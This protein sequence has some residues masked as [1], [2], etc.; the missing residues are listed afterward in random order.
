MLRAR[1][2]D[3]GFDLSKFNK[4]EIRLLSRDEPTVLSGGFIK[5]VLP[6]VLQGHIKFRVEPLTTI[7]FNNWR[8]MEEPQLLERLITL[9]LHKYPSSNQLVQ[10]YKGEAARLFSSAADEFLAR[11]AL[12]Q[13]E[14]MAAVLGRR[15]ISVT[16]KLGIAANAAAIREWL[17]DFKATHIEAHALSSLEMLTDKLL[18]SDSLDLSSLHYSVG[19]A[20]LS[21]WSDRSLNFRDR[22]LSFVLHDRRLGNPRFPRN[23]PNWRP[24]DPAA[25]QKVRSW[26]AQRDIVFFFDFVLPDQR[27]EHKRKDFWLQYVGQIQESQVA[28]CPEDRYRLKSQVK[29]QMAYTN[30]R[31]NNIS[32]FLMRFKGHPDIVAVEFN[33]SGN[34]LYFYDANVFKEVVGSFQQL[35]FRISELKHSSHTGWFRHYPP[36]VWQ[37]KVRSFLASKGIRP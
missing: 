12:T 26:L 15:G 13:H 34:A 37:R 33:Q 5:S 20:V 29:E 2:R 35:S 27:D 36:G 16:T 14:G 24:M 30:I 10:A 1:C 23:E 6:S 19:A 28:L 25:V 9:L 4:R 7:Y 32:A 31:D 21:P 17:R 11:E 22:L 8:T 3:V 18:A